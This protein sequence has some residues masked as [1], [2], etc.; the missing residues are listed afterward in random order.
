M[1][2]VHAVSV[3]PA[4][5]AALSALGTIRRDRAFSGPVLSAELS[6]S[7]LSAADAALATRLTYG[8]LAA[9]GVLDEAIGRHA[10][11]QLEPQLRDVLRLAAFELL[12]GRAPSYAV[13]DQAVTSVRAIR[14][15]ASGLANAVLRRL[16]EDAPEFPWGDPAVDRDALARATAH[17]R[18]IVDRALGDLGEIA[19][20]EML[21]CGMEQA[22][23]YVRLE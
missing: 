10:R 12:F 5:R 8:V 2:E 22:P 18:W 14:P 3:A 13:I 16:A 4:R 1:L 15:Q 20:R 6:K 23:V 17:P 9:E 11:G 21:A 19:G 7:K